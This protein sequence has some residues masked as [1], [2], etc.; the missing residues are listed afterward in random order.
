[1]PTPV[2]TSPT[3]RPPAV[4]QVALGVF[5]VGYGASNAATVASTFTSASSASASFTPVAGRPVNISLWGTW[6][7]GSVRL[8]RSFD[9]GTTWLPCTLGGVG[10]AWTASVSEPVWEEPEPGVLVRLYCSVYGTG[11]I[12][13]RISQ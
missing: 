4:D 10:L 13:Y 6:A 2:P 3:F 5:D 9:T 1:M 12:S 11:P 8:E 7:N